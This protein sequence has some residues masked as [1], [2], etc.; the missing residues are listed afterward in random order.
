MKVNQTVIKD[1]VLY[2]DNSLLFYQDLEHYHKSFH[3]ERNVLPFSSK[4]VPKLV[5]CGHACAN[6]KTLLTSF[7]IPGITPAEVPRQWKRPNVHL[8]EPVPLH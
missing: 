6:F 5:E 3:A 8:S 7:F 1:S 4:L 2:L